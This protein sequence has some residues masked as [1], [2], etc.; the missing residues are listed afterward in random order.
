MAGAYRSRVYEAVGG[1]AGRT[2]GVKDRHQPRDVLRTAAD[3]EPIAFGEA[4]DPTGHPGVDEADPALT[5]QFGVRGIFGIAGVATVDDQ[6]S[7]LEDLGKRDDGFVGDRSRGHHDPYRPRCGECPG[8][9]GQ[10]GDVR[11]VRA[12]VVADHLMTTLA[13]PLT[14]VESHFAQAHQTKLHVRAFL[15]IRCA[16]VSPAGVPASANRHIRC[17]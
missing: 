4:P 10:C 14:H 13:Q 15:G 5:E 7:R 12:R 2:Q 8:Q 9:I 17:S 16:P 11:D 6:I 3:H 1:I